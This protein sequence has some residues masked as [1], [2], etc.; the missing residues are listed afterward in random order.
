M[1]S[2]RC[3]MPLL[4][5][6]EGAVVVVQQLAGLRQHGD[7][8]GRIAPVV[9]ENAEQ[10]A[11]AA[12]FADMDGDAVFDRGETARLHDGAHH[13]GAHLGE[14]VAQHAQAL[15]REIGADRHHDQRDHDRHRHEGAEQ[16]PRRHAGRVHHDDFGIGRQLVEHMRD[17][18]QQRDR[19]DHQDQQRNDQAGDA[20]EHQDGL[21]LVG[22]QVDVAQRLRD[23]DHGGQAD[24]HDQ[25][26]T[27]RR[28]ENISA[29]GPHPRRRPPVPACTKPARPAPHRTQCAISVNPTPVR[30][31]LIRP[32][33]GRAKAK[34]L[35][36]HNKK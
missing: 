8:L 29:D 24:Q 25:E 10:L 18:D 23:P 35:N 2:W 3:T 21:T 5:D 9:E 32:Q 22:H 28:A 7:A 31:T 20:D 12:P 14:P 26:R 36:M 17:R 11:V 13:I 19:R 34:P 16:Q 15:R 1:G 33:S 6:Q 27:E 4:Q 30:F